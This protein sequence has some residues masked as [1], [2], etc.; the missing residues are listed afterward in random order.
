MSGLLLARRCCRDAGGE[1]AALR[2]LPSRRARQGAR[3]H[4]S[5]PRRR[6]RPAAGHT[7]ALPRRPARHSA[8]CASAPTSRPR[9]LLFQASCGLPRQINR[10]AHYALSAAA[11][12]KARTVDAEHMQLALDE[13]RP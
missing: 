4:R 2:A 10:I 13:L 8:S 5:A 1:A 11:L 3:A 7:R 12:A 6:P 9:D